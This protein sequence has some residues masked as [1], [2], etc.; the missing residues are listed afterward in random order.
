MSAAVQLALFREEASRPREHSRNL[1]R[2]PGQPGFKAPGPSE[3]AAAKVASTASRL[4]AEVLG[5]IRAGGPGTADEIASRM[6]RSPL[7]IR[8]RLSELKAAGKIIATGERRR[9]E[10]GMTATVW[11][12]APWHA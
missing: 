3:E 8:P 2:Y 4:R 11:R 12:V 7:S 6:Q 10:S 9:N 1:A 5:E